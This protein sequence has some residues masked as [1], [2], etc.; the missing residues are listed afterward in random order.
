[1]GAALDPCAAIQVSFDLAAGE[2]REIVFRLGVGRDA[3]DARN[4][5]NRFRGPTAARG[6]LDVVWQHWAHTLG[7]SKC[8]NT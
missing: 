6:A 3:D 2:E 7:A 5:V 4:L 1:M 8:G